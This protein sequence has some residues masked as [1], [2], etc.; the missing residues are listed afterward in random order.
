MS[1]KRSSFFLS[2]TLLVFRV[3]CGSP[4]PIQRRH[5]SIFGT[6]NLL[7]Q[8]DRIEVCLLVSLFSTSCCASSPF[9]LYIHFT[10]SSLTTFIIDQ[11]TNVVCVLPR[12]HRKQNGNSWHSRRI[13]GYRRESS[14]EMIVVCKLL[15]RELDIK[16]AQV[17][18]PKL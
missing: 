2:P 14:L 12:H 7:V 4:R 18:P 9:C 3:W 5:D 6:F 17:F 15:T 11:S 1:E 16:M 8:R 10:Y 13:R